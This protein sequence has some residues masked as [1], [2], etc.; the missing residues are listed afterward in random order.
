VR[1]LLRHADSPPS[2]IREIRVDAVRLADGRLCFVYGAA[3][4]VGRLRVPPPAEPERTDGLWGHTCFEA[5]VGPP[6]GDAYYEFNFAPSGRWAGY[7]F[8]TYRGGM[9]K[10]PIE[11]PV[12]RSVAQ[13][14]SL[15]LLASVGLGPLPEL[16]PWES[17]RIGISAVIEGEDGSLSYWALAHP[18]GAPDFHHRD[19]FAAELAPAATL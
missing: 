1:H 10:A 15:G 13:A 8:D 12:I 3:G 4:D 9:T 2:P 18:P 7:R 16:V 5:F 6:G 17:W 19:C 14:G 11:A